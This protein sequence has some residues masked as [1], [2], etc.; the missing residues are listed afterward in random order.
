MENRSMENPW[1]FQCKNHGKN[2]GKNYGKLNGKSMEN[3]WEIHGKSMGNKNGKK[4]NVSL[5][6]HAHKFLGSK[7]PKTG[8][9][10]GIRFDTKWHHNLLNQLLI[11]RISII[12]RRASFFYFPRKIGF[13]VSG[14]KKK[15]RWRVVSLPENVEKLTFRCHVRPH[16]L[17]ICMYGRMPTAVILETPKPPQLQPELSKNQFLWKSSFW[18]SGYKI[19]MA[20]SSIFKFP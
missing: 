14:T 13:R 5:V 4:G 3:P 15:N 11:W 20:I 10:T 7:P 16:R 17:K 6:L 1:K 8:S 12:F 9:K 19:D 2:N 18:P